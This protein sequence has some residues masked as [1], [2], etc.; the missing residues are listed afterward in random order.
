M[1]GPLLRDHQTSL[2]CFPKTDLVRKDRTARKGITEGEQ[3][4]LNLVRVQ[5]DLSVNECSSELVILVRTAPSGQFMGE[6]LGVKRGRHD[7]RIMPRFDQ[8]RGRKGS[9][10]WRNDHY[11]SPQKG[12]K[13]SLESAGSR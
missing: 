2:D 7:A 1:L 3:C 5:I 11:L 8:T 9:L 4:C 12:N 6:I 13:L 10:R